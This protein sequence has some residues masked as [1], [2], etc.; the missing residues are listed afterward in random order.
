MEKFRD[1]FREGLGDSL[2]DGLGDGLGEGLEN[3]FGKGLGK[4]RDV[5][6][7]TRS[8]LQK[9]ERKRKKKRCS[10]VKKVCSIFSELKAPWSF[11][12]GTSVPARQRPAV[13]LQKAESQRFAMKPQKP[14]LVGSW[15]G[16]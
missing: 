11:S 9:N 8:E 4:S 16:V 2:G 6:H 1:R 10:Q 15:S 13:R 12:D 7:S 3:A 14:S 5:K